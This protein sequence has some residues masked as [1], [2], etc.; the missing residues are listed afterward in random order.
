MNICML[1]NSGHGLTI[2]PELDRRPELKV[3]GF[4]EDY[5]GASCKAFRREILEKRKHTVNWY[6]SY[7]QMLD[8]EQPDLVVIDGIYGDHGGM[9]MEA[10]KRGIHVFVD[11]PVAASLEQLK[12]LKE[13]V[14]SSEA[15]LFAMLTMRYEAP[16]YT[17]RRLIEEGVI[18]RIRM[19]NGQKSYKLGKRPRFFKDREQFVG[20]TPWISIH[21]IDLILWITRKRCLTVFSKQ[22]NHDNHGYGDLEMISL[23]NMELENHILAS[24]NSDYYRPQTA[25]THGDDRLRIVG[26]EGILEVLD[27]R[28]TL[29][30]KDKVSEVPLLTPPDLFA[31]CLR[32]IENKDDGQNMDGIESTRISLLCRQS[33]DQG[34]VLVPSVDGAKKRAFSFAFEEGVG[35]F[36]I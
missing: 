16:Y 12:E 1:G 31:D 20:I 14:R 32:M 35:N 24:V 3:T 25:P 9:T 18:G 27:G 5:P 26:T 4:C 2:L 10:L 30:D 11:K 34:G 8:Q 17:A 23:C 22:D 29:I 7:E 15:R 33:A 21:M 13:V 6:T 36:T 19:L 28:L